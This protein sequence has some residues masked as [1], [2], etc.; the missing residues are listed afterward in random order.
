A[1]EKIFKKH[2][3]GIICHLAAQPGVRHSLI[4]PWVYGTTNVQGTINLMELA[5]DVPVKK[6]ILASSSSVYG[7]KAKI[8]FSESYKIDS[9]ASL[10]GA[11]KMAT[12][13]MGYAYHHLHGLK[14]VALRFF[15]AYG[16]WGRPDMAYF[17]FAN[18]ITAGKPIDIYN[19]GKMKRDFTYIDD[20]IDGIMAV[21]K[22]NFNYEIF[23]LGNNKTVE[24]EKFISL[25]ENNL[26]IKAKR[27]YLGNNPTELIATWANINRA[28]K[29]LGYKPK[30]SI[31]E[32]LKKF[33]IWYKDYYKK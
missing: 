20:I 14:V 1:L 11:T 5:K 29:M 6:F 4:D 18:L 10:Y 28:K 12:E 32:G 3:I 31:E 7:E 17:K 13:L 26:G 23:N 15:T 30:I 22:R 8:P 24:L 27:N 25:L 16:P 2:K 9:P 33:V 21:I 19:F